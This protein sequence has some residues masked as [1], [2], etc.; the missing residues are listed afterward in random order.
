[1]PFSIRVIDRL[2]SEGEFLSGF[3]FCSQLPTT[4]PDGVPQEFIAG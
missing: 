1:M 4:M 3:R 2:L